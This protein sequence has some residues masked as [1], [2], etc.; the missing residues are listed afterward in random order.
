MGRIDKVPT[1]RRRTITNKTR[2]KV[3]EGDVPGAELVLLEEDD[4]K[5]KSLDID[6][7]GV[8]HEDAKVRLIA[9]IAALVDAPEASQDADHPFSPSFFIGCC[10]YVRY[11]R[12]PHPLCP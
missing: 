4:S 5:H 9:P 1:A 3:I 11:P 12:L 10:P 2:L 8:E 7:A 6:T